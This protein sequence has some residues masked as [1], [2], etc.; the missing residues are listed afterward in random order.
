M[1]KPTERKTDFDSRDRRLMFAVI[2][3]PIAALT[4]LM[5]AYTLVPTSCERGSKTM[6]HL[7]AA[8]F[9]MIS[10]SAAWIARIGVNESDRSLW[11]ARVASVLSVASAVLI[12][13]ME[14]PNLILRSCD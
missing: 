4:Y 12:V 14:I 1:D 2:L 13:A 9:A 11:L 6:L 10:L 5:V 8:A 3:G 7:W